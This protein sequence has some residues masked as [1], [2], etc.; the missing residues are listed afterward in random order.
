M[1]FRLWSGP[2]IWL[3]LGGGNTFSDSWPY[4][5]LLLVP[6]LPVDW[7]ESVHLLPFG[8]S[9]SVMEFVPSPGLCTT[10]GGGPCYREPVSPQEGF[11]GKMTTA[12]TDTVPIPDHQSVYAAIYLNER[13]RCP[14]HPI[15]PIL[16]LKRECCSDDSFP[17]KDK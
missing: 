2:T 14:G 15:N 17:N 4:C 8:P 5:L 7:P 10:F 13:S 9:I 11:S 1:R 12:T 3:P 16:N 6:R